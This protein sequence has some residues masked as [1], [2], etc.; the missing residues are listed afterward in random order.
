MSALRVA[1]LTGLAMVAFASNSLL[2]RM[3]LK[4]TAI[5]PASFTVIRIVS[6]ALVLAVIVRLRSSSVVGT[7]S[8]PS[9]LALA[10]YAGAF[11]F[12][13]VSLDAGVGALLLFGAVQATMILYGLAH[14]ER[15]FA[16]QWLGLVLALGGL[17]GLLLPGAAAPPP[18]GASLMLAAGVAWGAYSLRGRVGGDPTKATA[19]NFLR[20]VPLV[21][22]PAL[23]FLPWMGLDAAGAGYA[24]A[25]GALASGI[26]YAIWYTALGGLTATRAA[27]VQLSVPVLA[28]IGGV[29]LLAE[30]FTMR[31]LICSV[32]VLGG[33]GLVIAAR[34]R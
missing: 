30:P 2:C 32:A 14:G 19:G 9:A 26:G 18:L 1:A 7:G 17:A 13:Y 23:L 28:A 25:S 12:A 8:W 31:L 6:G 16:A 3:A 33:I 11:S 24:L 20:A 15:L 27:S 34:A 21:A 29:L 10:A 5:D 22:I 4:G